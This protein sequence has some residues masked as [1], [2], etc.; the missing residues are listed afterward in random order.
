MIGLRFK[1]TYIGRGVGQV[2]VGDVAVVG[3]LV[4]HLADLL[5]L[6]LLQLSTI[7]LWQPGV[8]GLHCVV[9]GPAPEASRPMHV[10]HPEIKLKIQ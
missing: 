6:L 8:Q 7:G 3:V 5:T 4:L 10:K 1:P 9:H 2:A